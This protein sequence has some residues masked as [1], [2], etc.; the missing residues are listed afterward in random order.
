[1]F[2]L[3]HQNKLMSYQ[4]S[5][6]EYLDKGQ[7]EKT[8][9]GGISE[10]QWNKEKEK[11]NEKAMYFRAC[12]IMTKDLI[13]AELDDLIINIE[14]QFSKEQIRHI[15]VVVKS[16][17]CGLISDQDLIKYKGDGAYNYLKSS[18]VMSTLVICA[19][20]DTPIY[21]ISQVLIREKINAIPI[22][23]DEGYLRGI[24]TTSDILRL[25]VE[26]RFL[27]K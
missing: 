13:T 4:F 17:I 1:M 26:N 14:K 19:H 15:P 16:K 5:Y 7:L 9:P 21:K 18:D 8:K 2:Y 6:L 25:T 22:V 23:D 12:D 24:V 20:L 10:K 3:T 27:K 11:D